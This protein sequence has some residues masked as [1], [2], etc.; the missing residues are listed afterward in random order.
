MSV[1]N[2]EIGNPRPTAIQ[3]PYPWYPDQGNGFF[4]NPI[5]CADY[6]DPDVIRHGEDFYMTA[7]SFNCTPGLPILHS[8]DLVNWTIIAHAIKNVPHARYEQV[9]HGCGVWAPAIRFHS[10][11][12]WIFFPTPDEGIFVTTAADPRGPWS[13]PHLIEAGKGLIDPCPLW[14]NDGNAYLVHAYARSRSGIC[15]LLRVRPMAPDGSKLL[16]E[17]QIVFHSPTCHPTLEGPKFLKKDGWYY[18]LAPAGGVTAGWQVALRSK[19]IYGPYEDKIVLECGDTCVNGPHQGAMVD[20][21]NGEWWFIHFQDAGVYG[22]I[23]HL[24]PVQWNNDWPLIGRDTDGN[25]IGEPVLECHRPAVG[26]ARAISIPQTSDEFHSPELGLQW[27]WHANQKDRWYS[28]SERPGCMR[29]FAQFVPEANLHNAPNLLLQKFPARCFAV[30][31]SLTISGRSAG[32]EAGLVVMGRSHGALALR[33]GPGDKHEIVFR[34]NGTDQVI[35]AIDTNTT[36]LRVVVQDGGLCRFS[37][38][39]EGS[40]WQNAPAEFQAAAGVWIG[41][42]IGIY[43][44]ARDVAPA[45]HADFEYFRFSPG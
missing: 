8:R 35:S 15:D 5:I 1:S 40:P 33:R 43:S 29:L 23:V 24:Q 34:I 44:L 13:E 31:T 16:G 42:K 11:K 21:P 10:G 28:L 22:R 3:C 4:R 6:S 41:A 37:F 7:S 18:I 17:G 9:Q 26:R 30:E 12:F 45:G 19:H 25:G 38:C 2:L 14:D 39:A 32:E 20:L 27:Q 36:K